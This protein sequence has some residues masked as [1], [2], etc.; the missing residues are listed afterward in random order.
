MKKLLYII[1]VMLIGYFLM[2]GQNLPDKEKWSISLPTGVYDPSVMTTAPLPQSIDYFNPNS[3]TRYVRMPNGIMEIAPNVRVLPRTNSWQSEVIITRHPLNPNIMFG[4]SNAISN[5]G[6]L[7]ISEG[8]Y[9]TTNGGVNWFGSDT[10]TGTPLSNH[11]GDPGIALD[12]NGNFIMTHLGYSTSGIFANYSTNN[13]ATWSPNYTVISGSQ[14]KN[15]AGTDDAPSSPYY[16]RSYV[17]WS[18]F[19]ASAPPIDI[20]YTSNGGANWS[21]AQQINT[22]PSGH[23]SQGCDIRVGPNGEV[24]VV[25]AAP[26]SG[27]PY[28]EDF[29]GF[30][31]ST[32]GGVNWTVTEN[33]FDMNGIRGTFA[34]KAGMRVNSF[35]RIDVDRSGGPRNGW[36]YVAT[37]G[38][39]ISPAG[40]DPDILLYKSSNG[41]ANWSAGVRVNQDPINNGKYQWLPAIRVDESGGVNVVYYD[42]RNTSS[43]SGEVYVSRSLDGGVTWTDALISDHRFKPKPITLSGIAGGYAGDYIGVTS[44]NG[45]LWPLW[46]DDVT[47]IYQAWTAPVQIQTFPLNAYN[48]NTPSAGSRIQTLPNNTT[49]YTFTWDTAASTASYKWVFGSPT[50]SPR[51]ITLS[52]TGNTLS[53]TGGQLDNILAGLGLAQGDSLVGQWDIWAFRNNQTNDSLKAANGPRAITLKRGKPLLTAFNLS[54]PPNNTTL[55]TLV[56]NTTPVNINWTKS[57]EAVKY[58]WIY[59]RPN[60]S[61]ASN[62]KFIVQSNNS[63]FDSSLTVRNSQIDSLAAGI[64]VAVGDSSVGQW[65]VYGYSASDSLASAQTYNLTIRRGIPPTITTSV[66]SLI[67]DLPANQ[68]T[69]RNMNI[70]NTG[71]FPLNWVITESSSSLDN[72]TVTPKENYDAINAVLEKLPKG[73]TYTYNGPDQT[74]GQGGPDAGGYR[75][76]D[77]DEPG[78]PAFNWVDISSDGTAITTWTGT[79]DDGSVILPLPFTFT[80]YGANYT[81]IK[82]VTNGWQS[83]DVVS[84]STSFSNTAIPATALPNT[85]LYPFWDDLDLRTAGSVYYKNDAVNN[86]FIVMYKDVPHYT[87]GELY[88]FETIIYGDGRIYYQYLNMT[89]TLVNSCTIG[90][91]NETGTIGLQVVFNAAYLHNNLAIKIEKGLAW[92]DETPSSGTVAP[93]GSQPVVVSFNSTGLTPNTTY[94][95]FLNVG[96]NDPL[97]P[98]KNIRLKLNVGPTGVQNT[99][100]GIPS[101]FELNQNYPNPFNPS[102]VISYALPKDGYASIKVYN[103]LGKEV[104][105]LVNENKKAG[106]YETRFDGADFASG[107]YFYKIEANGFAQTRKMLL[108]K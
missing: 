79:A 41:G 96:S 24:Y 43:D 56:S 58:K 15:L 33:A 77:S 5:T 102:T 39:N 104:A 46:M 2:T 29:C 48:L 12:K 44:G 107:L 17:V 61:S 76:I 38:K 53:V 30:G 100:T 75:W 62:I 99:V 35:P 86:R 21:T 7:F 103:A 63:G 60:F 93:S 28:T 1:P 11:G 37:S 9:V 88:T 31:K 105:T 13:G 87:S 14:D 34:S 68:T 101:E 25:W 83:F 20:S 19:T 90:T 91:E 27:S 72:L 59:A 108:I 70:G 98:V 16:G 67:V 73:S 81:Q 89:S 32:N 74:D 55:L 8:V 71:Q 64:G 54:S 57:G 6:S 80:Y 95:G 66:D 10:C 26:I 23:Y 84:T 51:K 69:T 52:P 36:I 4:S 78:G 94:T 65:R 40:S 45:K 50:T 49:T 18:L 106:Y 22:P 85:A 82:V 47:G 92:V 3:V 97:R 42:D